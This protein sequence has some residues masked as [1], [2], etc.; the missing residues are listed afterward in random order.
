MRP[1][2]LCQKWETGA[3]RYI[4]LVMVPRLDVVEEVKLSYEIPYLTGRGEVMDTLSVSI[5]EERHGVGLSYAL[6]ECNEQHLNGLFPSEGIDSLAHTTKRIFQDL[7]M[8]AA[9][10]ILQIWEYSPGTRL[11][12]VEGRAPVNKQRD[13][14]LV[15]LTKTPFI[16]KFGYELVLWH[17]AV[18]AKDRWEHRFPTAHPMVDAGEWL[19]A[20]WHFSID[21]R[22]EGW[23]K[24]HYTRSERL[25]EAT[26]VFQETCPGTDLRG[27]VEELCHDLWGR[28]VTFSQLLEIGK[29]LGLQP[30][31]SLFE[32]ELQ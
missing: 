20:M 4:I 23:G 30:A 21:G 25:E 13:T 27:R 10:I 1:L 28:E 3:N 17:Q 7:G 9:R 29:D 18:H 32:A 2:C 24:P 15:I 11:Y 26:R 22:L 31:R 8:Q 19:D 6:L 12:S 16:Y 14:V 5:N